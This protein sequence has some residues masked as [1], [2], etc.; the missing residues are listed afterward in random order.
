[1]R[2]RSVYFSFWIVGTLVRPLAIVACRLQSRSELFWCQKLLCDFS[3]TRWSWG[4][5][6]I[7]C[8]CCCF[9]W[10]LLLGTFSDS[11]GERSEHKF[12]LSKA[13][14]TTTAPA[15]ADIYVILIRHGIFIQ[16]FIVSVRLK[17]KHLFRTKLTSFH[18][19]IVHLFARN[20]R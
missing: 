14:V 10:C 13:F 1:M 5:C 17:C 11:N 6:C 9:C 12:G 20:A 3:F 19:I 2:M 18:E 8:C 16:N 15:V 7:C 4:Y